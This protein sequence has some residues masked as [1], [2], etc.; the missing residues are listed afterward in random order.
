MWIVM[1]SG[2]VCGCVLMRDHQFERAP[3]VDE[4]VGDRDAKR[5]GPREDHEHGQPVSAG[6]DVAGGVT[7]VG[8]VFG[9]PLVLERPVDEQVQHHAPH[10]QLRCGEVG[11]DHA[12]DLPAEHAV[13]EP[14]DD[15]IGSAVCPLDNFVWGGRSP[16]VDPLTARPDLVAAVQVS[17]HIGDDDITLGEVGAHKGDW[18]VRHRR[19]L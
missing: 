13:S 4:Q 19:P 10:E 14:L 6:V 9:D 18:K 12:C 8:L 17:C 16:N 2:P 11:E 15:L 7:Q 5:G 1:A 3:G